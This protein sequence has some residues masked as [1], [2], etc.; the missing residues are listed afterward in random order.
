MKM[1]AADLLL[2]PGLSASA[3]ENPAIL[4]DDVCVSYNQLEAAACRAAHALATLGVEV[5]DRVLIMAD[6]RPEFFYAYLGAMKIG[7][8][9]VALNLR[10]SVANLTY[11]VA[12]SACKLIL[13]DTKFVELFR[14]TTSDETAPARVVLDKE[15][16]ALMDKQADTFQ[17][18]LLL[19]DDMAFWMYTSGTTGKPKAVVHCLRSIPSVERYLGPVFGVGP[20]SKIFCTSKLFFA[21][22]I[23]HTLLAG[24]RLGASIVLHAG[25][26]S[27]Q[28]IAE[29][30]ERHRPSVVFSVPTLYGTLLKDGL[31]SGPGF[32]SVSH[33]ISAGEHLPKTLF[34][35][36]MAVTGNP[37]LQGIGATEVLIMFIGNSPQDFLPGATGKPYPGTEVKLVGEN[38]DVIKETGIPGV[39]W[40][41]CGS[42]AR[43]YWHQEEKTRAAFKDGWYVTG[44]VFFVDDGGFYH[45]QGRDDDMLKISGQW[46]SP[47]EIEG[48]VLTN[49]QVSE[50][51]VIGVEDASGL[52]RLGLCLVP[53]GRK[54]DH[55]A[56][57]AEL[58]GA[59]AE[60]LSIYK[61]PRR[62]IFLDEMP[63]T[64]TGKI[65][66]FKLR[67][68]AVDFLE[69][70]S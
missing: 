61:C 19:P 3:G 54:T 16:P 26:P 64:S 22:S 20:G 59:L 37:I 68:L 42:L 1:N 48:H 2:A 28:S 47:A 66:R 41:R 33:F 52:V 40:V 15:F 17:S 46:V 32:E 70:V 39:L 56:L 58:I 67:Q 51:A 6:D 27:S 69:S 7:A 55:A 21:F 12:D 14:Q 23:G 63:R 10:F 36:W 4:S 44:D 30:I 35:K 43:E 57:E 9:P 65:Q 62:F 5:G 8:V 24:L 53:R 34:N 11:I 13:A 18:R 50:A 38:G 45:Y 31:T 60:K 49:P 29:V 25:W